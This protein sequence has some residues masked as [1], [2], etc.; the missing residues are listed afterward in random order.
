MI[1]LDTSVA[2][3]RLLG[4]ERRPSES[5]WQNSLLSS[6]LLEYEIWTRLRSRGLA[7]SLSQATR[8]IVDRVTFVELSRVVL[9]RIVAGFPAP[10]R[11][12]DAIH[13]ATLLYLR[14]TREPVALA[15]YDE[16]LRE[17]ARQL[18]VPIFSLD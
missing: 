18:G 17:T 8:R 11:T 3:A 10:V 15:T 12:L 9:D 2:L 1:Y 14:E 7:D 4:E 6:R 5:F 13:L 16:K